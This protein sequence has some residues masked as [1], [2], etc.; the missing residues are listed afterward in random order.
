MPTRETCAICVEAMP[1]SKR[2]ECPFC[3]HVSCKG[4]TQR[5]ILGSADDPQCMACHRR[6]DR[7]ILTKGISQKFVANDLKRHRESVLLERETAMM[8]GTQVYV[9]QE[10]QRRQN[11]KLLADMQQERNNLKRKIQELDRS[12]WSLTRQLVPPLEAERRQFVHRCA[13]DDCRG[14]LSS[15]WKCN[16]CSKYTC[17]ECNA[18]RG[19]AR[20]DDHTCDP[21]ARETMQLIKNDSRKCPGCGEYIYKVSG[22]DQM[23][24]TG[25]HTAFSWRSG[26]KINGSIHNPHF[27]EFQRRA[28][29]AARELGDI[30]CGG[31]PTYRQFVQ[32]LRDSRTV[33]PSHDTEFLINMHRLT[34]HIEGAEL[35]RYVTRDIDEH[36]NRDLRVAYMM[37]ELTSERFKEK[38]Q[39]REKREQ[40][41]RDISQILQMFFQTA[42]EFF[43]QAMVESSYAARVVDMH[44]L[45]DYFNKSLKQVSQKYG[46]VVPNIH[47]SGAR[48]ISVK[49]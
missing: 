47:E 19:Y 33:L 16:I 28:G 10:I 42:S 9:N 29:T 37:N 6:F 36:T 26:Q 18:P 40:K 5:Y 30:P 15:M 3:E 22:C 34:L 32:G 4:C 46:C 20:E 17:S 35:P 49:C 44:A 27:Y 14:Y 38:L 43:R 41:R 13:Q 1:P 25:C 12:C 2:F 11:I 21:S 48:M 7:E 24:C 31:M 23:W 8:P 39:Q 45:V